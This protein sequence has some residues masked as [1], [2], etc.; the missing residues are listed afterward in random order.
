M[1]LDIISRLCQATGASGMVG[2]Q[3]LDLAFT[4][5]AA[6]IDTETIES[7]HQGKTGALIKFAIWSGARLA[8]ANDS[9]LASL[10][11]FADKLGFAFQITDDLLDVTGNLSTLGK[12]PGKD[13]ATNKVT[14]VTVF[15]EKQA[16]EKLQL[17]EKEG[18]AYLDSPVF[19]T[20]QVGPLRELLRYA[21]HREK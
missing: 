6:G 19:L 5:Q 11:R 1:L 20:T 13:Q 4:G 10:E 21:I 7:I 12:T 14:W 9:Q 15:G 2:G 3:V 17:L 16:R 18:M 8:G